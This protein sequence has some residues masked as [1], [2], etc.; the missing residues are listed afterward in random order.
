[1][2]GNE[3]F[4]VMQVFVGLSSHLFIYLFWSDLLL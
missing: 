2:L 1:M 3:A 4:S